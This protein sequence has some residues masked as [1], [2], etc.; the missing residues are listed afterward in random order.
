MWTVINNFIKVMPQ[1]YRDAYDEYVVTV[2]GNRTRHRWKECIDGMQQVLGMPLGLM[3]VDVA[4][5][6]GSKKKVGGM[7]ATA[8]GNTVE[9]L[10]MDIFIIW[11]SLYLQFAWSQ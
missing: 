8:I 5:D 7:T 3:F 11:T 10:L 4:F 6:E 9:A 2:I 1:K